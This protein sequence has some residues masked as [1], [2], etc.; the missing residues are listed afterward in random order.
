M[1]TMTDLKQE[2]GPL[3]G[4][5]QAASL[6]GIGLSTL[7]RLE[8]SG[9]GPPRIKMGEGRTSVVRYP[10]RWLEGWLASRAQ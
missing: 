6:L 1:R 8:S 7:T 10:V 3:I 2:L 4:R 5:K 9:C